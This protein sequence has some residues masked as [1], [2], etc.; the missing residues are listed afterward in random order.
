VISAVVLIT[1]LGGCAGPEVP[2]PAYAATALEQ[3]LT[4]RPLAPGDEGP[5]GPV[6]QIAS[7]GDTGVVVLSGG[8]RTVAFV[9]ADL[10][11]RWRLEL[12]PIGPVGVV[13][14]MGVALVGDTL[15]Y[16]S[17]ARRHLVRRLTLE[18][19]DRG[20]IDVSFPV[21]ELLDTPAGVAA[22]RFQ[23]AG[24]LKPL[25]MILRDGQEV[26]RGPPPHPFP[27]HRLRMLANTM[28]FAP[29]RTGDLIVVHK[30]VVPLL[31]H[32]DPVSGE[33]ES[34]RVVVP[35]EARGSFRGVPR[36]DR[37]ERA[38]REILTP[39][40]AIAESPRGD[41]LIYL[42]GT[43]QWVD[44]SPEWAMLRVSRQMDFRAARLLPISAEG[45]AVL[46][47]AGAA[48]VADE[49]GGLHACPLDW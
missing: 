29:S 49:E 14:P 25:V 42:S 31:Y 21:R 35:R 41:D 22:L 2:E 28:A 45:F 38:V 47:A 15:L 26:G 39:A 5:L 48:I 37:G 3:E 30:M 19:V 11:E 16:V 46:A 8:S 12:S 18:G 33:Y 7:S 6:T 10:R 44:D 17:D 20:T 1:L 4:C 36:L 27:D 32:V 43:G 24:R 23:Q 13:A 34:H 9:G 40:F